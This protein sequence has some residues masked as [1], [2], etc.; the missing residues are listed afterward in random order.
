[1][2]VFGWMDSD[3]EEQ[4]VRLLMK[5][6]VFAAVHACRWGL[7]GLPVAIRDDVGDRVP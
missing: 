6:V 3:D 5:K 7:I 1:M 4:T 2:C